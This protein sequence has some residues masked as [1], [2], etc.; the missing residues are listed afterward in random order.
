MQIE[1]AILRPGY[2]SENRKLD[3]SASQRSESQHARA[4]DE[5][6]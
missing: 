1:I 3:L 5:R 6:E 4:K 2:A